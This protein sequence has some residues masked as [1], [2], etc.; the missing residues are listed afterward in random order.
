MDETDTGQ[1]SKKTSE[2][3][4]VCSSQFKSETWAE[5]WPAGSTGLLHTP[6][7]RG[8][9]FT[10]TSLHF[11]HQ[12]WGPQFKI[13]NDTFLNGVLSWDSW[14]FSKIL[15]KFDA[16]TVNWHCGSRTFIC[17]WVVLPLLLKRNI[18]VWRPLLC[19]VLVNSRV[20]KKH[21]L[22]LYWTSVCAADVKV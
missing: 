7:D 11:S 9:E 14:S 15:S 12:S 20:G 8:Q 22:V 16:N 21:R 1:K 4:C 13:R 10:L 19:T 2:Q 17:S 5:P 3:Y 18:W 6:A